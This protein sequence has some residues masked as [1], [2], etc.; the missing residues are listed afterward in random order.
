MFGESYSDSNFVCTREKGTPTTTNSLK[1]S[2]Y[3]VNKKLG[4]NFNFHSLRHTHATMLLERN[5]NFKFIQKRLGHSKL[6]TTMDIYSHVTEVLSK[7][8]VSKLEQINDTL[9]S[10][11]SSE[12]S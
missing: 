3:V 7:S 10:L 2:S 5:A 9:K 1:Y 12:K 8:T 11:P 4:I 6:E